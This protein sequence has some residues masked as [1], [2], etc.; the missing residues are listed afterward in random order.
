MIV[1]CLY[2]NRS[3]NF[4]PLATKPRLE[5]IKCNSRWCACVSELKN[6]SIF[7]NQRGNSF[8]ALVYI[9]ANLSPQRHQ[10]QTK[11]HLW[12]SKPESETFSFRESCRR[13]CKFLIL[14][15]KFQFW[16]SWHAR[17]EHH[18]L[19]Q[20]RNLLQT[21]ATFSQ[22]IQKGSTR[23]NFA[24]KLLEKRFVEVYFDVEFVCKKWVRRKA[25]GGI[26]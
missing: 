23:S 13:Q 24:E 17:Q 16:R 1:M 26:D 11:P 22:Q 4:I 3:L 12:I 18:T 9:Q 7:N 14:R 15:C 6:T 10:P 21:L 2:Y 20:C 5:C 25:P 19:Q 8:L